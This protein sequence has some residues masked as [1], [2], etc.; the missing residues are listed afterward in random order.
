MKSLHQYNILYSCGGEH[1]SG[2][3]SFFPE[4]VLY[5]MLSGI[6]EVYTDNRI[7]TFGKD[8]LCLAKRYQLIKAGKKPDG[9]NLFM[10]ISIYLDQALLKNYSIEH[11]IKASGI[12]TGKPNVMLSLD[13]FIF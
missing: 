7:E 12:Y 4:H 1:K 3:D 9:E 8:T 13:P 2:K 6:M 5:L 11:N 10:G